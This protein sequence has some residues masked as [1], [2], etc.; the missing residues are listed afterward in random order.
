MRK[1]LLLF[2]CFALSNLALIGQSYIYND[3]AIGPS[4]TFARIADAYGLGL[5]FTHKGKWSIGGSILGSGAFGVNGS[6]NIIQ[7][8]KSKGEINVPIFIG[9]QGFNS[10]GAFTF[11]AGLYYKSNS[12]KNLNYSIGAT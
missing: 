8:K 10:N 2:F 12:P 3:G 11:G 5:D 9:Y 4:I 6:L 1:P 7:S